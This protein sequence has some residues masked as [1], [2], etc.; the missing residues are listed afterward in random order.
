[1]SGAETDRRTIVVGID[2]SERDDDALAL[3]K[4]L[5]RMRGARLIAAAVYRKAAPTDPAAVAFEAD[6]REVA[7]EW[8]D[9]LVDDPS[10]ELQLRTVRAS[11]PARGLHE[12]AEAADADMVVV[13]STHRAGF[14]RVLP[15]AVGERLLQESP[16]AVAIAPRGYA[17]IDNAEPRV[18]AVGYDMTDESSAAV[19]LAADLAAAAEA[20]VRI[21]AVIEGPNADGLRMAALHLRDSLPQELRADARVMHGLPGTV[22]QELVDQAEQGVDLLVLGSRGYGPLGRALTGSVARQIIRA[23]PCPV[24]VV[25]RRA[26]AAWTGGSTREP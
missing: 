4:R 8:L 5:A 16:C 14:G 19:D 2:G 23:A 7:R 11:S 22:A 15:G 9:K 13:G 24:I 20:T 3:A 21:V 10:L 1:M 17:E 26:A 12:L 18:L 25:P 6:V